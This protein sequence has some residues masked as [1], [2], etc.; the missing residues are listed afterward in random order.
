MD[1]RKLEFRG[2]SRLAL[3]RYQEEAEIVLNSKPI[4]IKARP[5]LTQQAASSHYFY[6]VYK[7]ILL[8]YDSCS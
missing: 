2:S 7:D 6:Y 1:I 3:F 8:P 5:F 4:K